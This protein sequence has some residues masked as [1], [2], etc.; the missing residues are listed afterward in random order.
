[1]SDARPYYVRYPVG[2]LPNYSL[3]SSFAT[4]T[5]G[6]SSTYKPGTIGERLTIG[7]ASAICLKLV[8]VIFERVQDIGNALLHHWSPKHIPVVTEN[9]DYD[10]R[11]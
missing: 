6:I 3:L 10:S 4:A 2:E 1:M 7:L 9:I 5:H 8:V 11:A